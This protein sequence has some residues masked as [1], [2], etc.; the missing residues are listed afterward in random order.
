MTPVG[1]SSPDRGDAHGEGTATHAGAAGLSSMT[2]FG[3]ARAVIDGRRLEAELRTVNHRHLKIHT[4]TS[5]VGAG[6]APR[7]EEVVREGIRR[8]TV[9]VQVRVVGNAE[10]S[11]Y[12]LDQAWLVQLYR[13]LSEVAERE[14]AEVPRL[15]EV[16][17]LPGVVR[18]QSSQG[19][20][21][22]LAA[23][24]EGVVR[25]ALGELR[26]M[27]AREGAGIATDLEAHAEQIVG[28]L[29]RVEARG[30]E[31]LEELHARLRERVQQL[32]Q[33]TSLK[34]D[35]LAREVALLA[36]KT[37]VSEEVQRLRSHVEELRRTLREPPWPVG[38][39]LEFLAQEMLREANTMASKSYDTGILQDVLG[40]KLAVERIREQVANVE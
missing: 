8:G 16:A 15:A 30:P 13:E 22:A 34:P 26:A 18:E 25:E 3:S 36:D 17:Q 20:P 7:L 24:A 21:D 9:Y 11:G 28:G 6:W 19:D 1:T 23:L 38:R 27:R 5:E 40:I 12:Q 32:L 29:E 33:D 35:D 39:K 31:A 2:G 4:R 10:S 14:G 37:D